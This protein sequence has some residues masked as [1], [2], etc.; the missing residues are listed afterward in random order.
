[1]FLDVN[2]SSLSNNGSAD[3]DSDSQTKNAAETTE[4]KTIFPVASWD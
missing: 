2:S 3:V 4:V 1:V